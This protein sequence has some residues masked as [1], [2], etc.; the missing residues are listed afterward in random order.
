MRATAR[1][2]DAVAAAYAECERITNAEAQNFAYGI[3]L[4]P[5]AK[6]RAMSAV[7]ALARRIDE[8][9]TAGSRPT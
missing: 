7:Y 2:A 4:L 1:P 6:R 3:R 8:S 9:A 5:P